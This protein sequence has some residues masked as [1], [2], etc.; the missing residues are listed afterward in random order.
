MGRTNAVAYDPSAPSGHVPALTRREERSAAPDDGSYS[1][2]FVTGAGARM[3][4]REKIAST[5]A[6]L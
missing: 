5:S 4:P 2:A 3:P 1:A 6:W